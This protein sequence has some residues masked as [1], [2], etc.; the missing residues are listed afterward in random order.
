MQDHALAVDVLDLQAARLADA[1][2]RAIG[3]EH[4][5]A[6]FRLRERVEHPADLGATEDVGQGR[7]HL[8]VPDLRNDLRS[9]ERVRVQ[10]PKC[11]DGDLLGGAADLVIEQPVQEK[12]PDLVE[13]QGV[14]GLLV[15]LHESPCAA[16][17][18][19]RRLP[20]E[21]PEL[22]ILG[23]SLERLRNLV[24]ACILVCRG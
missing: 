11:G 12:R 2:P 7:A 10:E 16:T 8:G 15:V 23:H 18:L 9:P 13:L 20:R 22:E 3:R 6:V 5:R 19:L 24:H 1:Q 14:G 17:V 21:P 4:D